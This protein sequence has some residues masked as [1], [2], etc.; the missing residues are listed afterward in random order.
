MSRRFSSWR[1]GLLVTTALFSSCALP[2]TP[3]CPPLCEPSGQTTERAYGAKSV[4]GTVV[5]AATGEPIEGVNVLAEWHLWGGAENGKIVG[6]PKVLETTTDVNGHFEFPAW[7]AHGSY[8]GG[9]GPGAPAVWFFKPDYQITVFS[10]NL[11]AV[12]PLDMTP[13]WNGRLL[14][15][16]R[17]SSDAAVRQ[18]SMLGLSVAIRDIHEHSGLSALPRFVCA[19]ARENERQKMA[20]HGVPLPPPAYLK[21]WGVDCAA[22]P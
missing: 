22:S 17:A 9:P 1:D 4:Y 20:N 8:A 11:E 19:V 13:R 6:Y 10:N 16:A 2:L 3:A 15:M 21:S 12:N 5:D 18:S 14:K 7:Q